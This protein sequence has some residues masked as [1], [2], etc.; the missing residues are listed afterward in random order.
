VQGNGV[1]IVVMLAP[2]VLIGFAAFGASVDYTQ[3]GQMEEQLA[4]TAV[5][6]SKACLRSTC[7][8]DAI[9]MKLSFTSRL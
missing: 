3:K 4:K 2:N 9:A 7:F 6:S 1:G 5:S 8:V